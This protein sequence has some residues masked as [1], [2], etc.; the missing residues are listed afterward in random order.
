MKHSPEPWETCC[1]DCG[2]IDDKHGDSVAS[3]YH[4]T[5]VLVCTTHVGDW[6]EEVMHANA[7]R[8]VAC[9][10]ACAGIPTEWLEQHV[11]AVEFRNTI[12]G[13]REQKP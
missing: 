5:N 11:L 9:V 8:I 2:G 1:P 3:C 13:Q 6:D 4:Q 12:L 10:N 7:A